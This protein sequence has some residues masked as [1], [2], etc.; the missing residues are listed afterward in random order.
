M[1]A[2]EEY[3]RMSENSTFSIIE[4]EVG[5]QPLVA[6]ID[7]GLREFP[8]KDSL[9]FFLS[10]STS[11]INP[12]RNGLPNR[13]DADNLNA[14]E[15]MIEIRLL[16]VTNLA[17]V[18]RVTWNGHRELLYCVS[19]QKATVDAVEALSGT[20]AFVFTCEFDEKWAKANY[21]LNR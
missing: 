10:I 18:G 2:F 14:W 20:R 6:M 16:S 7:S 9:P 1:R 3:L 11:L 8:G 15:E 5:G 12:T 4:G 13:I 19:N 17:F 21:W